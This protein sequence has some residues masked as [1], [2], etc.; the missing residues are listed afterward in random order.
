MDAASPHS[1]AARLLFSAAG[2]DALHL[3]LTPGM[4]DA[5]RAMGATNTTVLSNAWCLPAAGSGGPPPRSP[6]TVGY[7]SNIA[8][9]K[10]IDTALATF[11]ELRV[12]RPDARFVIAGPCDEDTRSLVAAAAARPEVTYLGPVD[13][14][15]RE[16]FLAGLHVFVFPTRNPEGQGNVILEA[17]RSGVPV[18]ATDVGFVRDTVG[19]GGVVLDPAVWSRDAVA[20]VLSLTGS[21]APEWRSRARQQFIEVHQAAVDA[22]DEFAHVILERR[23]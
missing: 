1:R 19:G 5:I 14:D 17:N 12:Q 8:L 18:V 15:E 11:D 21:D 16:R 3:A 10:G 22:L 20:A 2:R 6:L 7:L 4:E 13:P 9:R 23:R